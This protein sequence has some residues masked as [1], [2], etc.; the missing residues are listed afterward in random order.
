MG[1][2]YC[3][4]VADCVGLDSSG[5]GEGS[6]NDGDLCQF[7]D[8]IIDAML[9]SID[10]IITAIQV[11]VDADV[12]LI[13]ELTTVTLPEL[14]VSI[15]EWA[16]DPMVMLEAIGAPWPIGASLPDIDLS[17]NITAAVDFIIGLLMIPLDLVAGWIEGLIELEMPS[18]PGIDVMIDAIQVLLPGLPAAQVECI[19]KVPMVPLDMVTGALP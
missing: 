10:P 18:V 15:G 16:A 13:L 5:M 7:F 8:P 17:A 1:C 19:A 14:A 6:A 4:P 2:K 3:G 9:L 12:D 11:I